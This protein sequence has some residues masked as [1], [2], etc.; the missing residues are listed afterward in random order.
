MAFSGD[1]RVLA[2]AYGKGKV[3]LWNVGTDSEA[4]SLESAE[5]RSRPERGCVAGFQSRWHEA[6]VERQLD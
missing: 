1:G 5:P 6:R 3:R 4:D 2:V